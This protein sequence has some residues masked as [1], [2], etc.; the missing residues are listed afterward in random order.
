MAKNMFRRTEFL[1]HNYSFILF[2]GLTLFIHIASLIWFDAVS[3]KWFF[4]Q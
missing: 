1:E 4:V 2:G 3:M